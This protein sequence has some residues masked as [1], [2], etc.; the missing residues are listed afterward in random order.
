[1][2]QVVAQ[3]VAQQPINC[4]SFRSQ[5]SKIMLDSQRGGAKREERNNRISL[6]EVAQTQDKNPHNR[7]SS[8]PPPPRGAEDPYFPW[9]IAPHRRSHF[10]PASLVEALS[11][12]VKVFRTKLSKHALAWF[13][14]SPFGTISSL[15]QLTE[16]FLHHFSMNKKVPK[17]AAYLFI[18]RQR[19]NEP[20][21]D[22]VQKFVEAVHEVPHVNHELLA[23]TIQQPGRFKESIAG[24]P[25]SFLGYLLMRSQ[26][27]IRIEESNVSDTSLG[28]KRK[29]QEEEK[30]SRIRG[31]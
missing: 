16:Y 22:Y 7:E 6:P 11:A 28:I 1:M 24:K 20:L 25:P 18:I 30:E 21:R 19:E 29:G 23:N 10:Y 27:Y 12:G 13:N 26:K 31:A 9:A 3:F 5:K 4:P 15:K 14:Q 2:A 17:T 8:T